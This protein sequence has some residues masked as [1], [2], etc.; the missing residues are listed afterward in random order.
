MAS[1][2][3]PSNV[4]VAICSATFTAGSANSSTLRVMPPSACAA[5]CDA[6]AS[7]S[8]IES[9]FTASASAFRPGFTA[10][11][12]SSSNAVKQPSCAPTIRPFTNTWQSLCTVSNRSLMRQ[13]AQSAG[14]SNSR[15]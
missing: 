11:V 1:L 2:N 10:S 9:L 14:T 4:V 13:P 6:L 12:T 15:Q 5:Y 3:A 7:V 8:E